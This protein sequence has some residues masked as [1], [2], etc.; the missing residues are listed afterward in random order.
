M[1]R[2]RA[3]WASHVG[4]AGRGLALEAEGITPVS[5][6]SCQGAA[7]LSLLASCC[8]SRPPHWPKLL[9]HRTFTLT[10]TSYSQGNKSCQLTEKFN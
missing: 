5:P 10:L 6:S 4:A 2:G 9:L 3:G 8:C 7:G 1:R